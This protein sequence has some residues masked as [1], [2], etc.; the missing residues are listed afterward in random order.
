[1]SDPWLILAVIPEAD[2]A[3]KPMDLDPTPLFY[4]DEEMQRLLCRK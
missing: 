2:K 3:S 4:W 1:M